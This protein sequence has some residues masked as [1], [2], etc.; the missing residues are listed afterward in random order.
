VRSALPGSTTPHFEDRAE[1]A[2]CQCG[3]GS[4]FSINNGGRSTDIG[5]DNGIAQVQFTV[6]NAALAETSALTMEPV[7]F[8]LL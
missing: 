5:I 4:Q 6:S 2:T 7:R 3:D 8:S 1:S